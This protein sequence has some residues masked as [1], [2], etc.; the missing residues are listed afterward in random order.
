MILDSLLKCNS[1]FT[2]D[3]VLD[4]AISTLKI[5]KE[6]IQKLKDFQGC[7]RGEYSNRPGDMPTVMID[8]YAKAINLATKSIYYIGLYFIVEA[9]VKKV[10]LWTNMDKRVKRATLVQK[11]REVC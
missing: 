11:T 7:L 3:S 10:L 9:L 6:H 2:Y 4:E 8:P 1:V 5:P